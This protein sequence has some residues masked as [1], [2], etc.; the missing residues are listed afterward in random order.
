[1]KNK[2]GII[3]AVDELPSVGVVLIDVQESLLSTI[4]NKDELLCSLN[5]LIKAIKSFSLPLIVTKQVPEKLGLTIDCVSRF[6]PSINPIKKNSFSVFGSEEFHI[7]L[8]ERKLS[9]LVFVG[10]ETSIC[11]YLSAVDALKSGLEVTILYDCVGARRSDDASIALAKLEKLGCHIIPLES[12]IYAFLR[13]ADHSD[14]R[15]ISKLI[16]DR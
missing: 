10:I 6:M 7:E 13:T 1:M 14:F 12:F 8:N 11:I 3:E 5:I 16:R 9:H 4:A 15:E 2:D